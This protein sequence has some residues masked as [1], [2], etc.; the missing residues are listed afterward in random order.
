MATFRITF[1][2]SVACHPAFLLLPQAPLVLNYDQHHTDLD[3]HFSVDIVP[4]KFNEVLA[5]GLEA[6]FKLTS[7]FSTSEWRMLIFHSAV[8][9]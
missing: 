7:R 4:D 9:F 3:V 1:P 6:K 2:D 5:A 8:L